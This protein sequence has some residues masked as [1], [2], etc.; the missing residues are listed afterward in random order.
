MVDL[1]PIAEDDLPFCW[2]MLAAASTAGGPPL[3]LVEVR[4]EPTLAHY[5]DDWGRPGDAGV[6]A[7]GGDGERLGAAWYRFF[8]LDDPSYGFVDEVTPELAIACVQEA[9]GL[10]IGHQLI[11][12]LL[13]NAFEAA[14]PQLCL[15]VL[16]ANVVGRRVYEDCG[17]IDTG[18]V[19][20]DGGA[21]T[22]VAAT[23]P[24]RSPEAITIRPVAPG[25]L[26]PGL[27]ARSAWGDVIGVQG[28]LVFARDLPALVAE[29][30]GEPAGLLTWRQEGDELEIVG[31][32]A[33]TPD[34][35]VGAALL[36]TVRRLAADRGCRRLWLITNNDNL[37]AMRFYQRRGWELVAIHRGGA[38][39]SRAAKPTI[40]LVGDHGIPIHHEVELEFRLDR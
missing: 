13:D 18:Q 15:S 19:H 30:G 11:E 37:T 4:A 31:V 16:T 24:A 33:W 17:F 3:P 8:T 22:L 40:P 14:I 26:E 27:L 10:G 21:L 12:A 20:G 9:R 39:R 29:I 23:R 25:R 34:A 28:V 1:R 5:L 32:E 35:G 2:E 6:V 36:R 38:D 7:I